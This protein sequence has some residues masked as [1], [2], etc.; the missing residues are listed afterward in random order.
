MEL[1]SEVDLIPLMELIPVV[2][3]ITVIDM[4]LT[5]MIPIPTYLHW[6]MGDSNSDSQ[7]KWN[8]NTSSLCY[9]KVERL[10]SN[11]KRVLRWSWSYSPQCPFEI[12]FVQSVR[13]L[14]DRKLSVGRA[15]PYYNVI[16]RPWPTA[17][18]ANASVVALSRT[19]ESFFLRSDRTWESNTTAKNE[20]TSKCRSY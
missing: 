2:E 1:I 11:G 13:S 15:P 5:I 4:I 9:R 7:K 3:P 10:P 16:I 8:H 12:R 6:S 20:A 17:W 19:P 18:N 14:P